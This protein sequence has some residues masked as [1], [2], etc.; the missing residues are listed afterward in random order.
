MRSI[1]IRSKAEDSLQP[2]SIRICFIF[3]RTQVLAPSCSPSIATIRL[4]CA[5]KAKSPQTPIIALPFEA[6]L[7]MALRFF[8]IPVQNIDAATAELNSFLLSFK[9]KRQ[10]LALAV[11]CV[12][13]SFGRR[14]HRGLQWASGETLWHPGNAK[15]CP[16]GYAFDR[17]FVPDANKFERQW[18]Q[19]PENR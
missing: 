7:P 18:R 8:L 5:W 1:K 6:L 10:V 11:S 15:E 19:S 13:N 4:S 2:S 9:R 3:S 14:T 12:R 16:P 17:N